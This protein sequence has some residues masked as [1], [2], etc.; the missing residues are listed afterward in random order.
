MISTKEKPDNFAV[1]GIECQIV[2]VFRFKR[3]IVI[4]SEIADVTKTPTN[5]AYHF[6]ATE[7]VAKFNKKN[8]TRKTVT[9]ALLSLDPLHV[10]QRD[11]MIIKFM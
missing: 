7:T 10:K 3:F 6:A 2:M 9:A 4:E 8:N 5:S 1:T 11:F